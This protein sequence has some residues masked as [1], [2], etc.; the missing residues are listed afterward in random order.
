M[1]DVVDQHLPLDAGAG[2]DVVHPVERPQERAL[3]AAGRADEGGDDVRVNGDRDVVER[4]GLAVEEVQPFRL[5]LRRPVAD[6]LLIL[7][8]RGHAGQRRGDDRRF[9]HDNFFW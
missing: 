7:G 9:A 5:D 2:N 4:P 1:S 8:A 3:A 6:R